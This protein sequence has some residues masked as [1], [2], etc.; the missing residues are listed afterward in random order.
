MKGISLLS[1]LGISILMNLISP[2]ASAS[3]RGDLVT[4]SYVDV[5]RYLGSWYQ[6]ARNPLIFEGNCVCARQVLRPGKPGQIDVYNS[7]NEGSPAGE[8]REIRGYAVSNDPISNSKLTVDFNLPHKG[9]YWIIALDHD[10][11]YAVVSDPSR[12]SLYILSKTP[13]LPEDLYR[14]A[15]NDAAL[16][17]DISKLIKPTQVGCTYPN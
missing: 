15:L 13:T 8:L 9:Q 14:A 1:L 4:V 3:S 16:Q 11:R 6:V 10:Y 12:L 2:M 7:C 17:M 5:G